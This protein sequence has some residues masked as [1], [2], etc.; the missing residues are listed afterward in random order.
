MTTD[1]A[2]HRTPQSDCPECEACCILGICCPP[3]SEAQ[4]QALAFKMAKA[5]NCTPMEALPYARW[6]TDTYDLAPVGTLGPLRDAFVA[7]TR[8]QDAEPSA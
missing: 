6:L 2:T 3:A 8:H 1:H 7:A 4:A 5:M